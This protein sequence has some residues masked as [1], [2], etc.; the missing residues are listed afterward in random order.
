MPRWIAAFL[1]LFR[2]GGAAARAQGSCFHCGLPLPAHPPAVQFD[3]QARQVC[4]GG[5]AA[6]V[7][8]LVAHGMAGHYRE[9]SRH[10]GG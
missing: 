10:A 1:A 3:G 7:E 9:R 2:S 8:T 6:I 5:C 4:C